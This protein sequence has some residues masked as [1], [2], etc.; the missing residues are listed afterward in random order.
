MN[1]SFEQKFLR[2]KEQVGLSKDMEIAQL[3]GMSKAALSERKRRGSFPMDKLHT[4]ASKHP[5][6]NLDYVLNGY[7]SSFQGT[8]LRFIDD[9]FQAQYEKAPEESSTEPNTQRGDRIKEQRALLG[10]SQQKA[11]D[12]TDVRRE[13]WSKYEAGA[14]PGAN[15]LAGMLKLGIDVEYVLAGNAAP[16]DDFTLP[17]F[18]E[19]S[20]FM[21]AE[22]ARMG[23]LPPQGAAA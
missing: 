13:M 17:T 19:M 1:A 21:D 16:Q 9:G 18:D 14:E 15:A 5:G 8:H 10:L 4:L 12:A 22:M 6:I 11:A 2:L 23:M 3:L 7:R 20:A